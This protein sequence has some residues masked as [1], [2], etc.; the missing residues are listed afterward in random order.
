M[1]KLLLLLII[2]FLSFGQHQGYGSNLKPFKDGAP[3]TEKIIELKKNILEFNIGY[4]KYNT[5]AIF[6]FF[7]PLAE[8]RT[9]QVAFVYMACMMENEGDMVN[10]FPCEPDGIVNSQQWKTINIYGEKEI[11][12]HDPSNPNWSSIDDITVIVS[13]QK[14]EVKIER[15]ENGPEYVFL[16]D[17]NFEPG[18]TIIEHSY[19]ANIS[20]HYWDFILDYDIEYDYASLWA[21]NEIG[22][23]TL[24]LRSDWEFI[25]FNNL[26]AILSENIIFSSLGKSV[27][28]D[29]IRLMDGECVIQ[30]K[31][32]ITKETSNIEEQPY[33]LLRCFLYKN[34]FVFDNLN[35]SW[36]DR[37]DVFDDQISLGPLVG[38]YLKKSEARIYRNLLFALN[39]HVF[40]SKDLQNLFSK[41]LWYIPN[42]NKKVNI[43]NFSNQEKDYYDYITSIEKN[44]FPAESKNLTEYLL[45]HQVGLW[46]DDWEVENEIFEWEE[47]EWY[48]FLLNEVKKI[49]SNWKFGDFKF[50]YKNQLLHIW[51]KTHHFICAL[52]SHFNPTEIRKN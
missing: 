22:D 28:N 52:D 38:H 16:F 12:W 8:T 2:P 7:N 21:S 20:S 50:Q 15:L 4:D 48:S 1:K 11:I 35:E 30:E 3:Y 37:M 34:L 27:T 36:N 10:M 23:F 14:K 5:K 13:G 29:A 40:K 25:E 46:V 39:G 51:F 9:I 43:S 26:P 19:V 42:K 32:I 44:D 18:I 49:D 31:N 47:N 24:K 6:H 33:N 45:L 17:V 41:Q